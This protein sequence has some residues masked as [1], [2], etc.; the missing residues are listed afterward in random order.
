[1]S[2]NKKSMKTQTCH[3]LKN[4]INIS[5][6]K[7][8]LLTISQHSSLKMNVSLRTYD[9]YFIG[10]LSSSKFTSC[11]LRSDVNAAHRWFQHPWCWASF[12]PDRLWSY[13]VLFCHLLTCKEQWSLRMLS[14]EQNLCVEWAESRH[15]F[16]IWGQVSIFSFKSNTL[17][18]R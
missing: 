15:N 10:I 9:P 11:R 13:C 4:Y 17:C 1:M 12:P 5:T 8:D 6:I 7:H 18:L 14:D 2:D 3:H 16:A